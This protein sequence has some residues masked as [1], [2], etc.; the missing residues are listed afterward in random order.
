MALANGAPKSVT[1]HD[2][3]LNNVKKK[4]KSCEIRSGV[5]DKKRIFNLSTWQ[6]QTTVLLFVVLDVFLVHL[7]VPAP[8]CGGRVITSKIG[9]K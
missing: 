6:V 1:Q 2:R 8:P 9:A 3:R 4:K 7:C 5:L